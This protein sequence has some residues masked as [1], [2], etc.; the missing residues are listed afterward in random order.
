MKFSGRRRR[1]REDFRADGAALTQVLR[2]QTHTTRCVCGKCS[3]TDQLLSAKETDEAGSRGGAAVW[4]P[5]KDMPG[6]A[7]PLSPR[8]SRSWVAMSV[9]HSGLDSMEAI[10]VWPHA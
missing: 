6:E 2:L 7:L 3:R 5:G 10:C 9:E 1:G 8:A 4:K